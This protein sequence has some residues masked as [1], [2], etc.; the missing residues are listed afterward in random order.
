MT[1]TTKLREENK[2]LRDALRPFAKLFTP[3]LV[4]QESSDNTRFS[5]DRQQDGIVI[6]LHDRGYTYGGPDISG[7]IKNAARAMRRSKLLP[8]TDMRKL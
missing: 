1:E 2:R 6:S 3:T 4:I 5:E 8:I 7:Y